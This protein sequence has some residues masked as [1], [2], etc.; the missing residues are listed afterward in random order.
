MLSC[1]LSEAPSPS[2][3]DAYG[4]GFVDLISANESE[5]EMFVGVSYLV[6]R[7]YTLL[8]GC[9]WDNVYPGECEIACP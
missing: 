9:G 8:D 2:E 3:F 7:V 5:G 4:R 6:P 1:I